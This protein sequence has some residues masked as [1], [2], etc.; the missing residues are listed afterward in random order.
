MKIKILS[1]DLVDKISAGEVIER[2]SSVIKEL[3][4][5]SID[6]DAK[7]IEIH[8]ENAGKKFI[9]VKDDGFGIDKDDLSLALLSHSTS[10][11]TI[12]NLFA[13]KT[14][15][16]RGEALASI[17]AISKITIGSKYCEANNGYSIECRGGDI[18]DVSPFSI[19]NGTYI[20]IEDLFSFTPAR[21]KFL[22][23]DNTE[24]I[25]SY[26]IFKNLALSHPHIS[27]KL[28]SN[29]KE[30]YNYYVDEKNS[31]KNRVFQ[32]LSKD[33]IDNSI[34]F[35]ES[36]PLFKVYGYLGSPTYT[37]IN[38][39]SQYVIVN[40]RAL[41][42]KFL[43]SLVRVAYSNVLFG[44]QYPCYVI[45]LD[46]NPNEI[47]VNVNPTKSEIRFK[48]IQLVR[49]LIISSI[50]KNLQD[51]SFQINNSKIAI[52]LLNKNNTN[53][54]KENLFV[55]FKNN[56]LME[57]INSLH[58]NQNN[59]KTSDLSMFSAN[60]FDNHI[61]DLSAFPLGFAKGQFH[62]NWIVAENINGIIIVDQHAAHERIN[63]EKLVKN[64]LHQ[65]VL[66]QMLI[67]QEIIEIDAI[68][69]ELLEMFRV[70]LYKLG[71]DF[72]FF[73]KHSIVIKSLPALLSNP[74]AKML[75]KD[76]M[77]DLKD[78]Q[79]L[80]KFDKKL[81]DVVARIACHKSIRS[82]KNL[83]INE[84]NFLL[85]EME[86]TPNYGQCPHGRPTFSEIKLKNIESLFGRT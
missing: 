48:D 41:K 44:G 13:I 37:K 59:I 54:P 25:A 14:L 79:S 10:K 2:P 85:R 9:S 73:S 34:Y 23:S 46:I 30:I 20:K 35:E 53:S 77:L 45:F 28:F 61:E 38:S 64:Y 55:E 42:D 43:N 19:N 5:N 81:Y 69:Y 49:H 32:I 22:R 8:I 70:N 78:I 82:G 4:E 60:N 29:Q 36:N 39:E 16:F 52:G 15:G 33:F 11:L 7:N 12:D 62:K 56:S 40:G 57:D 65:G 17:A 3:V 63:Q 80:E 66:S 47:D 75:F 68:E 76:L 86:K 27:F 84:M 74:N 72:D 24:N 31:L 71:I 50:K 6:A 26:K 21:L 1:K 67:T 51:T 83:S 18:S 58:Y